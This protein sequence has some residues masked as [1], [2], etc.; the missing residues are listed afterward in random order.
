[1]NTMSNRH[2]TEDQIDD[3]LIGDL[4]PET[5]AHLKQCTTCQTRLEA[6]KAPIASFRAVSMAWSERRS[7]TVPVTLV[8]AASSAGR[9]QAHWAAAATAALAVA[10]SVPLMIHQKQSPVV[11]SDVAVP[12][13]SAKAAVAQATPAA[14]VEQAVQARVQP[15]TSARR[16]SDDA[17]IAHDNEML[18]AIHHELDASVQPAS[19]PFGLLAVGGSS[20]AHPRYAPVQTWD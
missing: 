9:R 6:A 8:Q 1:M 17:E 3:L 14:P 12:Q 18:Q 7:A 19:D 20:A 2:L 15:V 11:A 16:G 5:T 10:L 13:A 4:A